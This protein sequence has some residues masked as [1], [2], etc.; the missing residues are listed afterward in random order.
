MR[1]K[2][3]TQSERRRLA[4]DEIVRLLMP[5]MPIPTAYTADDIRNMVL[6]AAQPEET[7]FPPIKQLK[8]DYKAEDL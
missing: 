5:S 6:L 3:Y 1:Q 8:A 7:D 2:L 4:L